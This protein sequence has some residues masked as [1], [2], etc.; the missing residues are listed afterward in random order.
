MSAWWAAFARAGYP[1]WALYYAL[2][3]EFAGAILLLLGIY[4]RW[5]SLFVL[6]LIVATAQFWAARKGFWYTDA[7]FELPLVW[8]VMLIVQALLGDGAYALKVS[9]LMRGRGAP[10]QAAGA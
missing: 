3:A 2:V 1:D 8:S 9:S 7:G 5:V 10:Q 6:P 4:T